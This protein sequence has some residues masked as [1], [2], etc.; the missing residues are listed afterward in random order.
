M[1]NAK[2]IPNLKDGTRTVGVS[3]FWC[4]RTAYG[5]GPRWSDSEAGA[6]IMG[7]ARIPRSP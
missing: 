3:T 1:L 5:R 4:R 6:L 7:G 2:A